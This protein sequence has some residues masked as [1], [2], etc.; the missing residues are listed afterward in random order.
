MAVSTK[1][2]TMAGPGWSGRVELLP[3]QRELAHWARAGTL[4]SHIARSH[5]DW[6][7]MCGS[8]GFAL[9]DALLA[10]T[11]E[12]V[13]ARASRSRRCKLTTARSTKDS[14]FIAMALALCL[15]GLSRRR[16]RIVDVGYFSAVQRRDS[17]IVTA[18]GGL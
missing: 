4:P 13:S 5:S 11:A 3:A 1:M 14:I 18:D 6:R 2:K 15:L 7:R 9:A 8:K 12:W 10:A 17:I 16:R